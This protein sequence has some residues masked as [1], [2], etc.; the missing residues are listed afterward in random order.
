MDYSPALKQPPEE[1][2]AAGVG[3]IM[4]LIVASDRVMMSP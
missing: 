1:A 4:R 2:A 3:A